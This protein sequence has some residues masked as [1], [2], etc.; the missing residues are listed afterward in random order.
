MY[1]LVINPL[2]SSWSALCFSVSLQHQEGRKGRELRGWGGLGSHYPVHHISCWLILARSINDD[3]SISPFAKIHFYGFTAVK[4]R[5]SSFHAEMMKGFWCETGLIHWRQNDNKWSWVVIDPPQAFIR[6]TFFQLISTQF[7][8]P[9]K[10]F[11]IHWKLKKALLT[12]KFR[13]LGSILRQDMKRLS[14]KLSDCVC[15]SPVVSSSSFVDRS[16]LIIF[17]CWKQTSDSI[18]NIS[19]PPVT[20]W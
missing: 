3:Q 7:I 20:R 13:S 18:F 11:N 6:V 15:P 2:E 1:Y 14:P 9:S 4:A 5:K 12:W 8:L 19:A 16:P 10:I 17:A